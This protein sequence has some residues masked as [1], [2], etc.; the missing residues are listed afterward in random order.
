MNILKTKDTIESTMISSVKT[1]RLGNIANKLISY[2]NN[3]DNNVIYTWTS[4]KLN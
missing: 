4:V 2:C 1:I 3:Y